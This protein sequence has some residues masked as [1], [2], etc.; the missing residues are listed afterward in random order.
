MTNAV[1]TLV[2]FTAPLAILLSLA[3]GSMTLLLGA[4]YCG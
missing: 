3:A 4:W 1:H 2:L